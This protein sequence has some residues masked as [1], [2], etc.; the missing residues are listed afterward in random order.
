[1]WFVARINRY[2]R[3]EDEL[4]SSRH[5]ADR[6]QQENYTICMRVLETKDENAKLRDLN[7]KL[8]YESDE[9][10]AELQKVV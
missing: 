8:L 5:E 10:K 9:A 4:K 1:M 3:I 7:I 6:L 2:E